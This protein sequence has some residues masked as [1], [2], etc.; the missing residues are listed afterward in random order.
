[1]AYDYDNSYY[2]IALITDKKTGREYMFFGDAN[3]GSIC[4]LE[5]G[6]NLETK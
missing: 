4:E 6:G 5:V 1:M 3:G 2:N